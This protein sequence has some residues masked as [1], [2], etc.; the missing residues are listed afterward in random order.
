LRLREE[1][2]HPGQQDVGQNVLAKLV[3]DD[4][5]RVGVGLPGCRKNQ[6]PR[7]RHQRHMRQRERDAACG[8]DR[9]PLPKRPVPYLTDHEVDGRRK[10]EQND[11][12]GNL[13]GERTPEGH[14]HVPTRCVIERGGHVD[15]AGEGEEAGDHHQ[16]EPE[17]VRHASCAVRHI[18]RPPIPAEKPV[19]PSPSIDARSTGHTP[20][21]PPQGGALLP[22]SCLH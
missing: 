11:V 6:P 15:E 2:E 21:D 4:T 3:D 17:A 18:R 16:R 14:D 22:R 7:P 8:K 20:N 13:N 19:G 10:Q 1:P 12:A 5:P 9:D